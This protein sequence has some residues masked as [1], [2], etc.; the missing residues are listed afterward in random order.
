[1]KKIY[2]YENNEVLNLEPLTLTRP[3]FDLRC[4]AFTFFERIRKIFPEAEIELFVRPE[5]AEITREL[6]PDCK[7]NPPQVEQGLWILGN[8]L[9][10]DSDIERISKNAYEMYYI[11]GIL[12]AAYLRKDIA[13]NWLRMGGPVQGNILACP[14]ISE[15]NSKVIRYLWDAIESIGNGI[16]FD[17]EYYKITNN[18]DIFPN[19]VHLINSD[20]IYI[21]SPELVRPGVVIDATNGAVII[22]DDV[23]IQPFSFLQGP[24]YIGKNSLIHSQTKIKAS[25][26]GPVCKIGGEISKT[27]IQGYTNK[28]HD[29]YLGNSYLGQWLNLGAGTSSSNLKNNYSTVN[30][31][32]N[33]KL[34][35]TDELFIGL[36][37]GDYCATAIGTLFN[38]GTNI[39]IACM[40]VND[41][42][43]TK[44]LPSFTWYLNG[45]QHLYKFDKFIASAE[46]KQNRRGKSL[47]EAETSVLK[48]IFEK[49]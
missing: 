26:I 47:S 27:I 9:W 4:G 15:M 35:E 18:E 31:T 13:N 14:T 49:Q 21:S 46:A 8:V 24:I 5:I 42:F 45:K 48:R 33:K 10:T 39:G 3:V 11:D 37:A 1:M 16:N 28:K 22:D 25:I 40:V 41:G 2:L 43:P 34:V 23:E 20:N 44:H 7:V 12:S 32:I 29:G 30:V 36:L 6:Y 17:K 38:T 19:G